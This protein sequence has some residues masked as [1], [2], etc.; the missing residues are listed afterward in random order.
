MSAARLRARGETL[1]CTARERTGLLPNQMGNI[2]YVARRE[3]R[4]AIR[5]GILC[6]KTKI[7]KLHAETVRGPAGAPLDLPRNV[8]R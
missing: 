1:E 3:S 8:G 5:R 6:G 4:L 2:G 7:G